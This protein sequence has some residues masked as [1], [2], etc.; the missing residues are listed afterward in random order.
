LVVAEFRP[1]GYFAQCFAASIG[2][3]WGG[4]SAALRFL[5]I[6]T[7]MGGKTRFAAHPDPQ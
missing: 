5:P 4:R 2:M 3:N 6:M 1:L 7:A